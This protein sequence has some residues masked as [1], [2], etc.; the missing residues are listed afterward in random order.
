MVWEKNLKMQFSSKTV[1]TKNQLNHISE[2][3]VKT[4]ESESNISV[5]LKRKLLRYLN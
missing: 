5:K 1:Y 2:K 3:G 4:I